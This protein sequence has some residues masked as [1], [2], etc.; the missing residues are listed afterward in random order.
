MRKFESILHYQQ[1]REAARHIPIEREMDILV[2][3]AQNGY[4]IF[5]TDAQL[6]AK[7]LDTELQLIE[8]GDGSTMPYFFFREE[9]DDIMS[10]LEDKWELVIVEEKALIPDYGILLWNKYQK[11]KIK[12]FDLILLYKFSWVEPNLFT[13]T[14]NIEENG[15]EYIVSFD[16]SYSILLSILLKLAAKFGVNLSV[17][18]QRSFTVG[19]SFSLCKTYALSLKTRLN[20]PVSNSSE[21]FATFEIIRFEIL[22]NVTVY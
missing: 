2:Y 4:V 14:Y 22:H 19:M 3:H 10:F 15:I 11:M 9:D 16:L 1:T 8:N 21:E 6:I 13:F 7:E 20:S 17:P 18:H 5:D 12:N